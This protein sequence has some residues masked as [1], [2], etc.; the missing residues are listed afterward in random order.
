MNSCNAE[1]YAI[2]ILKAEAKI[3]TCLSNLLCDEFVAKIHEVEKVCNDLI[4][5]EIMDLW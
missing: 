3:A 5:I 1:S 4:Q 2:E